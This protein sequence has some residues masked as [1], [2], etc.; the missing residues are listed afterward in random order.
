MTKREGS[1]G[2]F[3]RKTGDKMIASDNK[4]CENFFEYWIPSA[5]GNQPNWS[6]TQELK[7]L[8]DGKYR[9]GAYIMTN[10]VPN[11]TV[12]VLKAAS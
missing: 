6:I 11:E 4:E 1:T 9:L 2:N 7:D 12:S 3:V 5:E 10:V 8:P